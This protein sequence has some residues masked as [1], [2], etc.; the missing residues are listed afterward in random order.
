LGD[1]FQMVLP[2]TDP[3]AKLSELIEWSKGRCRFVKKT[4]DGF[5]DMHSGGVA[6]VYARG[7]LY[8]EWM[9]GTPFEGI[10]FINRFEISGDKIVR[11]DV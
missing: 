9:D 3:M 10:R 7:T 1:G 4:H 5:D 2:G 8:G 11:Q 6:V